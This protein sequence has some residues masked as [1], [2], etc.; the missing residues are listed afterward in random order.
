MAKAGYQRMALV[1]GK[2]SIPDLCEGIG[3]TLGA[4]LL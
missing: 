2:D 1:K 3:L 4:F